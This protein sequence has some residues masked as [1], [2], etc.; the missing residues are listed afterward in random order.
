VFAQRGASI[1]LLA[2]GRD[3][4]DG[5]EVPV[6]AARKDNLWDT[7]S[8]DH[9]AHGEFDAQSSDHSAQFWLIRN[10]AWLALAG[11]LLT[12]AVIVSWKNLQPE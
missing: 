7:V 1:G 12:S 8:G 2:G 6:Q 10:R 3:G 11:L 9:G 5:A 4:L